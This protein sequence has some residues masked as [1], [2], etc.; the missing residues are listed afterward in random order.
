MRYVVDHQVPLE[1]CPTSNIQTKV[2]ESFEQ[3]PLSTYV[4]AGVPVT[5]STDNRLFSRTTLTEE[6]WRV[7]T[8]CGVNEDDLR[9]VALNSFIHSFLP[10]EEKWALVD[11][12]KDELLK[13]TAR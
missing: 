6:L 11:D 12:V 1:I 9:Q 13:P 8:L 3:H 7:H 10:W 5:I 2:V 4:D